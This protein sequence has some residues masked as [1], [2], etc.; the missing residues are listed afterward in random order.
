MKVVVYTKPGC[1]ACHTV[2]GRF[3]KKGI[4]YSTEQIADHPEVFQEA[5]AAGLRAFPLVRVEDHGESRLWSGPNLD[6]IKRIEKACAV[7]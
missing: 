2:M 6:E 3:E 4:R 1:V 7:G 5:V